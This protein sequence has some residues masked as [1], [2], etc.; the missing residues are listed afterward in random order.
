MSKV[1]F[2]VGKRKKKILPSSPQVATIHALTHEGLGVTSV[3]GKKVFV[4]G[5]LPGE[6][7]QFKYTRSHRRHD[8]GVLTQIEANPSPY[9]INPKCVHFGLC[10]GCSLQHILP[11]QQLKIKQ[12]IVLEQ[13]AHIG[14]LSVQSESLLPPLSSAQWGYRTKGRLGVRYVIKKEE[15]L[16]GFR[17]RG[18]NK[19]AKLERCEVL[20]P[21][22]G[23]MLSPLKTMIQSL[24]GFDAIPQIEFAAGMGQT[25]LIIRHL[26]PLNEKDL[27]KLIEFCKTK[28]NLETTISLYLQPEGNHSCYQLWPEKTTPDSEKNR[29]KYELT[30]GA[31]NL[32]YQ[33]HPLDFTQINV[34]MNEQMVNLAL[35]L[36]SLH[37]TDKVLDLFCGLGNFSLAIATKAAFVIGV[38]G[39]E[40]MVQ[41]ASKN[42]ALN[43]IS[44]TEFFKADLFTEEM[45]SLSL[46]VNKNG[47]IT[48][49]LLDP[50][51][52]GAREIVEHIHL[53]S[54]EHIVYISCNSATFARDAG[55]LVNQGK[56]RLEKVGI[57]DMFPHT[58][59]VEVIGLFTK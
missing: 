56:Y 7:V 54:P 32:Q 37:S 14:H 45:E 52:S 59:H 35:E 3:S 27:E 41:R 29:L 58:Q 28:S 53:F 18:S 23:E 57:M 39:D 22:I 10:G 43:N 42:A 34:A 21:S 55:I 26:T 40:G 8:E 25:A 31:H 49:I 46:R 12:D 38:E 13:L 11:S 20:N 5:A 51:R 48:K 1:G 17:E 9:R 50:P 6:S 47:A 4:F 15:L 30:V 36:L 33:F 2:D 16:V 19:I 24:E 44:N